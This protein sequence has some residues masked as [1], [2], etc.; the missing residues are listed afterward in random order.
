MGQLH[1]RRKG[2]QSTRKKPT[3][4]YLEEKCKTNVV[5]CTAVDPSATKE[6]KFYSDLCGRFQITSNKGNKYIYVSYVYDCNKI[7]MTKIKK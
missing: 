7:L 4:T 3:D 5:F 6:G 2:I 1:M